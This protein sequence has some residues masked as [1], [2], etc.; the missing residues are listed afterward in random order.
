[1]KRRN[2]RWLVERW[3]PPGAH[4]QYSIPLI[5]PPEQTWN[6]GIVPRVLDNIRAVRLTPGEYF[7]PGI[8]PGVRPVV[9]ENPPRVQHLP[10]L[11]EGLRD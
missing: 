6:F 4:S 3:V 10:L 7:T 5:K 2:L 1:M 8:G 11:Q 9:A